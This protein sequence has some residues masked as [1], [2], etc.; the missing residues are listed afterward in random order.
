MTVV[1]VVVADDDPDVR[2]LIATVLR[3]DERFHVA[4]VAADGVELLALVERERPQVALVDVRMPAGGEVAIRALLH[5]SHPPVVVVVSSTVEPLRVESLLVAGATGVV[6]KN[7]RL[8]EVLPDV[9]AG[10]VRGEVH[11]AVASGSHVLGALVSAAR[12]SA[13]C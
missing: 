4:G 5:A 11:L 2:E 10:A 9:V 3:G 6:D 12:A 8:G 13:F 7:R 1:S